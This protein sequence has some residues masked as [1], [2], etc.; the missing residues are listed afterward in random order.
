MYGG[1][2]SQVMSSSPPSVSTTNR[3]RETGVSSGAPLA[4]QSGISSFRPRG[5]ITAPDRMW[6]PISEPFSNTATESS[7]PASAASCFSR[8]AADRPAGPP[9]TITTSYCIDS[10]VGA[11]AVSSAIGTLQGGVQSAGCSEVRLKHP[12]ES[13]HRP[14]YRML[15]AGP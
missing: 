10:R 2:G 9:P 8:I 15:T 3:S 12:F 5:S 13:R 14:D 6:A 7:D 1:M 11:P 4:F